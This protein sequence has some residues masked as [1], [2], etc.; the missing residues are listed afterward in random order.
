[1]F[2][3]LEDYIRHKKVKDKNAQHD[4]VMSKTPKHDS[5]VDTD[6]GFREDR[7]AYDGN[8]DS[9]GI[10]LQDHGVVSSKCHVDSPND[11]CTLDPL[12]TFN[13]KISV[14][15]L[16]REHRNGPAGIFPVVIKNLSIKSGLV[17]NSNIS[18]A[19]FSQE[20]ND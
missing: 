17:Q 18:E 14:Q 5:S 6:D 9:E 10:N 20:P 12:N 16:N 1:M 7:S 8:C 2:D 13:S 15:Q 3:N 11:V 19:Q 4:D